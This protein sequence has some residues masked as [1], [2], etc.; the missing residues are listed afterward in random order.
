LGGASDRGSIN[1]N[2]DAKVLIFII[3]GAPITKQDSNIVCLLSVGRSTEMLSG[4]ATIFFQ[5]LYANKAT[6]EGL[7][8]QQAC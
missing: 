5:Q 8:T 1:L 2:D 6:L 4:Y 3:S 7:Q